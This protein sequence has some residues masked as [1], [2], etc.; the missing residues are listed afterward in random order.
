MSE[1]ALINKISDEPAFIWWVKEV[2]RRRDRILSK[3]KSRYWK[4]THKF[5]IE[6]PKNV[7]EAMAIDRKHGNDF[8]KK[9]IEKEMKNVMTAFDFLNEGENAP[10]GYQQIKLHIIFDI[11]MDFT[12]KAR[13]VAGG[14]MTDTPASLTYS[15]FVSR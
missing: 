5:G 4:R 15:S 2:L 10:I 11:K 9:A 1:Y 8:W 6:L 3:V 14:H 7:D 12:R 13:L